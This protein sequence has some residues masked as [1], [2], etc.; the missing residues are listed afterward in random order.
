MYRFLGSDL[1]IAIVQNS[2]LGNL[3]CNNIV[4]TIV[5]LKLATTKIFCP[6]RYSTLLKEMI[7]NL[8]RR[9]GESH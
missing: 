4:K 2:L 7:K 3:F 5:N 9:D 8:M 6:K 1:T